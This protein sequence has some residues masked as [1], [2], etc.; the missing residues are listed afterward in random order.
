M[1]HNAD[2]QTETVLMH[3]LRGAGLA[4]LRGM[5]PRSP[6]GDL[7][8]G[9]DAADGVNAGP[10]DLTLIRP[11]L[12]V[13]RAD[14]EAYCRAHGLQPRCDRSNLDTTY[15]RN[16]L[17]LELIPH[18]E[19]Y[20][21]NVRELIRRSAEVAAADYDVLRGQVERAWQDVLQQE[22]PGWIALD[23]ARWRA[24]P[25]GLQRS[26]L[27]SAVQVLRRHLRDIGWE[28]IENAVWIARERETGTRATLPDGLLLT[29]GYDEL[30]LSDGEAVPDIAPPCPWLDAPRLDVA[31]PGV[32]SLGATG[33][34]VT[35]VMLDASPDSVRVGTGQCRPLPGLPRRRPHGPPVVSS[36]AAGRPLLP[37]GHG[38]ADQESSRVH[39]QC[40]D[41]RAVAQSAPHPGQLW[42]RGRRHRLG[43]RLAYRRRLQGHVLDAPHPSPETSGD[44]SRTRETA[45]WSDSRHLSSDVAAGARAGIQGTGRVTESFGHPRRQV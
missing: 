43:S 12:R 39:D 15:F 11:L 35:A 33:W 32:T 41:P 23:L 37:V 8:L 4:G 40:Q 38:R 10:D 27:R 42:G 14:I 1:G 30:T 18:L 2:D 6:M 45:T 3:W 16:R 13:P 17:R 31:V 28:H 29:V 25:L 7:R 24:L 19:S 5:L 34:R 21:P 44:S 20:N 9:I 22:R 26:V 36:P